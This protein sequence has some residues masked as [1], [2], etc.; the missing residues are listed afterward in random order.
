MPLL[1]PRPFESPNKSK[2]FDVWPMMKGLALKQSRIVSDSNFGLEAARRTFL[3]NSSSEPNFDR[4]QT[5]PQQPRPQPSSHSLAQ[6]PAPPQTQTQTRQLRSNDNR[7]SFGQS[8]NANSP[9]PPSFDFLPP[10]NFDD[11]QTSIASYDSSKAKPRPV[12]PSIKASTTSRPLLRTN[13]RPRP[14]LRFCQ[15]VREG[16]VSPALALPP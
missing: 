8:E 4:P 10:I 3:P 6:A 11:F 15:C 14:R 2:R 5:T 9:T 12:P 13:C 1:G 16:E 7:F